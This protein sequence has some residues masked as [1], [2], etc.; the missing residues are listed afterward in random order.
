MAQYT[1]T[2]YLPDLDRLC[3]LLGED[4]LPRPEGPGQSPAATIFQMMEEQDELRAAWKL[5]EGD[6]E[7][8]AA[9]EEEMPDLQRLIDSAS[10]KV[11]HPLEKPKGSHTG[12]PVQDQVIAELL[13]TQA[14]VERLYAQE[15]D[16]ETRALLLNEL[17]NIEKDLIAIGV[18]V[19]PT[20]HLRYKKG[21]QW[22]TFQALLPPFVL[23]LCAY[24][25]QEYLNVPAWT[26]GGW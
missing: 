1:L 24:R 20:A 2:Q 19:T 6:A 3:Q 11:P 16:S 26:E 18:E 10:E 21:R 22:R 4:P 7:A 8:R 5:K 14:E 13:E 23:M 25:F 12:N 17:Q 9:I 15:R